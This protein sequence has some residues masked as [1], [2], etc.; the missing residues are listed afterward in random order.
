MCNGLINLR[1]HRSTA[2]AITEQTALYVF[3]QLSRYFAVRAHTVWLCVAPLLG[4]QGLVSCVLRIVTI[5]FCIRKSKTL[6]FKFLRNMV[7][8]LFY[9]VPRVL[10]L[11][12]M[13]FL[14]LCGCWGMEWLTVLKVTRILNKLKLSLVLLSAVIICVFSECIMK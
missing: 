2:R 14:L 8:M 6:Y 3:E 10:R 4:K 1:K 5:I 11:V 13:V 7:V 9:T 12:V